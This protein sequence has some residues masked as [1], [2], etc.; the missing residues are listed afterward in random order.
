MQPEAQQDRVA[1]S[2]SPAVTPLSSGGVDVMIGRR[3]QVDVESTAVGQDGLGCCRV[4][5][6]FTEDFA[7]GGGVVTGSRGSL[8]GDLL[9][10]NHFLHPSRSGV[11]D[12]AQPGQAI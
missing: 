8:F 5:R 6:S 11:G 9:D 10:P 12:V 7:E 1:D 3:R 2:H 4:L